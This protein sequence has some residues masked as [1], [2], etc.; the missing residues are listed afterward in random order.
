MHS[1]NEAFQ[2][3][4][5]CDQSWH[6]KRSVKSWYHQFSNWVSFGQC[7]LVAPAT[8]PGQKIVVP[9]AQFYECLQEWFQTDYGRNEK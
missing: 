2:D 3:C 4:L 8:I 9:Q 7:S 5:G 1:M 6:L